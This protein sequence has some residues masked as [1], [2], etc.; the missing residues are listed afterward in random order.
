MGVDQPRESV[1]IW[2]VDGGGLSLAYNHPLTLY[3]LNSAVLSLTTTEATTLF[4]AIKTQVKRNKCE[5]G[6]SPSSTVVALGVVGAWAL[7]LAA[8][9]AFALAARHN[10]PG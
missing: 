9:V 8:H 7:S 2:N 4:A 1:H 3:V 10:Y 5:H 6:L